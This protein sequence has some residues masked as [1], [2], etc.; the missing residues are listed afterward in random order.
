MGIFNVV[1]EIGDPAGERFIP[2]SGLV[3]MGSTLTALPENLLTS[4]GVVPEA[5]AQFE[6]ADDSTID[7]SY[8]FTRLRYG[9]NVVV[10][11][12]AFSDNGSEPIIGATTL[13]VL[14]LMVDP[15]R[16]RLV[17]VN[18]QMR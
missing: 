2:F 11:P 4:L 8:G 18:F 9:D 10:I 7:R 16:G 1:M 13:E 15:L 14:A 5:T 17:P 12:V 3:D 6:L